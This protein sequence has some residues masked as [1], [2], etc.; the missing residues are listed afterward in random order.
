MR[1]CAICG[2]GYLKSTRRSHSMRATTVRLYPNLQWLKLENGQRVKA[3]TKCMKTRN[4]KL[5]KATA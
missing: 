2:K 5:Q 4:K 1:K 3:C